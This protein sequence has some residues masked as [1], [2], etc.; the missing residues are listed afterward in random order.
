MHPSESPIIKC[1]APTP[2]KPKTHL[3]EQVLCSH[4]EVPLQPMEMPRLQHELLA[5]GLASPLNG[6]LFSFERLAVHPPPHRAADVHRALAEPLRTCFFTIAA[7]SC[8]P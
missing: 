8:P 7:S 6:N 2:G 5:Q 4:E 1:L 3:R